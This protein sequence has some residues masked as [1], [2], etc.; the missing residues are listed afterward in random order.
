MM[1][2]GPILFPEGRGGD[3]FIY[4]FVSG[5][6]CGILDETGKFH[7]PHFQILLNFVNLRFENVF[8]A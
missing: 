8:S 4:L 6:E 5:W 1:I 3:L 2:V 7:Y